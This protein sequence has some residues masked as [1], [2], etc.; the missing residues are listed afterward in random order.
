MRGLAHEKPAGACVLHTLHFAATPVARLSANP[1]G[2][3]KLL[4]A[5]TQSKAPVWERST[6]PALVESRLYK[7]KESHFKTSPPQPLME[8]SPTRLT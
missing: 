5:V 4:A 3:H 7:K 8:E 2:V 6:F 1:L